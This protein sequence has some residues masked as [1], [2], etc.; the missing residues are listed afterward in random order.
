MRRVGQGNT[1]AAIRIPM[2][3][4]SP[5]HAPGMCQPQLQ[6]C[7]QQVS[8]VKA[9]AESVPGTASSLVSGTVHTCSMKEPPY[10]TLDKEPQEVDTS[11]IPQLPHSATTIQ[12]LAAARACPFFLILLFLFILLYLLLP[13]WLCQ[14]ISPWWLK[15][16]PHPSL[17]P[18]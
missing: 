8:D 4:L 5:G 13:N 16:W 7:H 6:Y 14:G 2:R 18:N 11:T 17:A 12:S 15:D 9:G 10:S 1:T 3:G